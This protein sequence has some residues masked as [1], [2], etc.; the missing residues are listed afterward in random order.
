MLK[1]VLESIK[2]LVTDANFDCL[3][4]GFSLQAMDSSH[5]ALLLRSDGFEH[6]W[7]DRNISMGM[8]LTSMVKMLKCADAP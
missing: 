7:C 3:S 5:V 6:Y 8:N 2:D 1:K 4:T